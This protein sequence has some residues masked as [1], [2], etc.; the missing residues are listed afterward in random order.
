LTLEIPW[1]PLTFHREIR[2]CDLDRTASAIA[3]RP[4]F[5]GRKTGLS[6]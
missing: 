4:G 1:Q 3:R 6:Q 5:S 2:V